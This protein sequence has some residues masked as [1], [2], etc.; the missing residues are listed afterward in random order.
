MGG[1][2]S[3]YCMGGRFCVLVLICFCYEGICVRRVSCFIL[4]H[5]GIL[6]ALWL[7][8]IGFVCVIGVL[9]YMFSFICGSRN[10]LYKVCICY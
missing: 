5:I 2:V 1:I 8:R 7:L 10:N 4:F 6:W 9:V 3:R